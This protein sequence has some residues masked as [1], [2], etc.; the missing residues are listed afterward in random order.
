LADWLA[1]K[2]HLG[3]HVEGEVDRRG[4]LRQPLHVALRRE[5]E[6]LVLVE[7]H[8]QELEKLLRTVG[9]LLQLQELAEP[10]EM[11]VQL[12][13]LAVALVEPVRRDTE[14]G[15]AV[16]LLGADLHLEELAAGPEDRGVQRLVGVRLGAR[17]VVLDPLLDRGPVVVDHAQHVVALRDGAHDHPDGHQVVDLVEAL[18]ALPHLLE[19]GP[20][21]LGTAGDLEPVDAGALELVLQRGPELEDGLLPDRPLGGD[22]IDQVAI[23]LGLQELERQILQLGLDAGHT[24]PVGQR[25]VDLAGLQG[26]AVAALGRQVLQRAH[27]VQPVAQL[28]DDDPGVLRDREQQLPV[29]LHLFLGG[30]PEGQAGDLGEPVHDPG[31]LGAELPGDVLRADVRVLDHVVQQRGGDGGAVEQLLRQNEGHGDA[32]GDEVLTR[33]PLLAPVGGRAEAEGPIDEIEVQPIGVP[34]QHGH[35]VGC[36]LGQG[37]GH[38]GSGPGAGRYIRQPYAPP[39]PSGQG[40]VGYLASWLERCRQDRPAAFSISGWRPAPRSSTSAGQRPPSRIPGHGAG[41]ER[42]VLTGKPLMSATPA[43]WQAAVAWAILG[44]SPWLNTPP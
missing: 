13:G 11:L 43:N 27:V 5:D 30:A 20:E 28:D 9:V 4:P 40:G 36:E 18:I 14:L 21:V 19:D 10:A 3:V 42:Y 23:V 35:Q 1:A 37:R 22:L 8:L 25:S 6:D 44:Y 26:D 31:D 41:N 2:T 38:C 15:R 34:F 39:R 29:V 33:H 24:E 16:H 7:V 32:V 12:V 17:D